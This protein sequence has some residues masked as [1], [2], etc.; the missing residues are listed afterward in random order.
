MG[1]YKRETEL[2]MGEKNCFLLLELKSFIEFSIDL[3]VWIIFLKSVV[4]INENAYYDYVAKFTSSLPSSID[5]FIS[6]GKSKNY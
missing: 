3:F 1:F 2:L 6:Y 4:S 5:S